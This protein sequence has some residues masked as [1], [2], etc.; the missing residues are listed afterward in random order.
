MPNS[1]ESHPQRLRDWH[2]CQKLKSCVSRNQIFSKL[3]V[4]FC[5]V[6]FYCSKK[7]LNMSREIV[8]LHEG[9]DIAGSDISSFKVERRPVLK[10]TPPPPPPNHFFEVSFHLVVVLG[11]VRAC[12]S[13]VVCVVD[14]SFYIGST[15]PFFFFFDSFQIELCIFV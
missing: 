10:V 7:N 5:P 14:M 2:A 11:S 1:F 6:L 4:L 13:V 3:L 12:F 15:F 8:G 9:E